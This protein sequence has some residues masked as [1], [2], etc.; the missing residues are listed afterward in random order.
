MKN[1]YKFFIALFTIIFLL[2]DT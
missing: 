2:T 1:N